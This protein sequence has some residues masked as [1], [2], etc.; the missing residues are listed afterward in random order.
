MRAAMVRLQRTNRYYPNRCRRQPR[1]RSGDDA[2]S[3]ENRQ[4]DLE[5]LP[6]C[7]DCRAVRS[8]RA[9]GRCWL[10]GDCMHSRLGAYVAEQRRARHLNPQ[11]LA[12]AIGYKNLAKGANRILA[13][14]QSGE[15]AGDLLDKLVAVLGLDR[16]HVYA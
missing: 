8:Q 14:E 12:A 6:A 2:L 9:D 5:S 4:S 11:Q 10:K 15:T 3:S 13:L 7:Q 1:C 16:E